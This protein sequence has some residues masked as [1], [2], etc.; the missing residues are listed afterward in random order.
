MSDEIST[1]RAGAGAFQMHGSGQKK[2]ATG[3][4]GLRDL[5]ER[6][7]QMRRPRGISQNPNAPRARGLGKCR[8]SV[9]SMVV[10]IAA[11]DVI[12]TVA[13][14][15]V[16]VQYRC[17]HRRK[18]LRRAL[19]GAEAS[20]MHTAMRR[21][22]HS[23]RDRWEHAAVDAGRSVPEVAPNAWANPAVMSALPHM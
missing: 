19:G 13:W 2:M 4:S 5:T 9:V 17:G 11:V 21:L 22:I 7:C 12:G 18:N 14:L 6:A 23:V 1:H 8:A 15:V 16:R 20:N 3:A 10:P